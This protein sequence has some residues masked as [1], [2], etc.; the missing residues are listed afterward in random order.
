V[1]NPDDLFR[2]VVRALD[3]SLIIGPGVV[4]RALADI[5]ADSRSASPGQY[6]ACIPHIGARL[7]SYLPPEEATTR[8]AKVRAVVERAA[9]VPPPRPR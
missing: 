7:T 4:K 5:G 8:L 9:L 3:L 6:R 1:T 2:E